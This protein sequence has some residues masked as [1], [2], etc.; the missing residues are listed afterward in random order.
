[1]SDTMRVATGKVLSVVGTLAWLVVMPT[2]SFAQAEL[3]GTVRDASGGVM[4]GVVD[5]APR[6]A[7]ASAGQRQQLDVGLVVVDVQAQDLESRGFCRSG[8][9]HVTKQRA[10]AA[11]S[12]ARAQRIGHR[13]RPGPAVDGE[14]PGHRD[15]V[16][17]TSATARSSRS[18]TPRDSAP[19]RT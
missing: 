4:P 14:A 2:V 3:T 1:M 10:V 18:P 16:G 12:T 5:T 6:A 11:Q 13:A 9:L 17:P 7:E 15:G 8:Q 19:R